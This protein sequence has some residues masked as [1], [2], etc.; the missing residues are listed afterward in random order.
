[1]GYAKRLELYEL[2]MLRSG[3]EG[4]KSGCVDAHYL[5]TLTRP[6]I[7]THKRPEAD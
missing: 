1:L 6:P 3:V 5:H 7:Q 2:R 4:W